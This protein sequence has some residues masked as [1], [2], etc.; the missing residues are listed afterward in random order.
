MN[1]KSFITLVKTTQIG[2][3]RLSIFFCLKLIIESH[4]SAYEKAVIYA[5]Y[6]VMGTMQ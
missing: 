4:F 1:L 3:I 6:C 2:F 5:Q